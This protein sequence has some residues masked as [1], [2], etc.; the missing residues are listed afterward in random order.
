MVG[1]DVLGR[2]LGAVLVLF[3]KHVDHDLLQRLEQDALDVPLVLE[4]LRLVHYASV[5][6]AVVHRAHLEKHR[7]SIPLLPRDLLLVLKTTN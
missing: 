7:V 2:R 3:R 6:D 4:V 1:E 5:R